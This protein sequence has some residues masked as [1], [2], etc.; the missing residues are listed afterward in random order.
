[1]SRFPDELAR[2]GGGLAP[3]QR[4]ADLHARA[5]ACAPA[6]RAL[7]VVE[8]EGDSGRRWSVMRGA[9]GPGDVAIY[10]EPASGALGVPTGR[11]FLRLADG[12]AAR[13]REAAIARAGYRIAA[14]LD[15]APNA[16]WLEAEDGDVATALG[17]LDRLAA[18][19]GVVGVEPQLLAPRALR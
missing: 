1:M 5:G 8:I 19:D 11:V 4:A 2:P 17:R 9:P 12:I 16:A 3:L 10:R 15:Y 14:L 18:I 6:D 7:L 13:Q